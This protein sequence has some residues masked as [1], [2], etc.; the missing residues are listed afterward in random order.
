VLDRWNLRAWTLVL[1]QIE[2]PLRE[3]GQSQSRLADLMSVLRGSGRG[4]R[5]MQY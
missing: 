3:K 2:V 5:A 4:G 1:L